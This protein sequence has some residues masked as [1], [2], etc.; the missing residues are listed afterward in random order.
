M[1]E[2][3]QLEFIWPLFVEDVYIERLRKLGP[4]EFAKG[5]MGAQLEF[6]FSVSLDISKLSTS[7]FAKVVHE[8][9]PTPLMKE[10]T[11]YF[12]TTTNPRVYVALGVP[13]AMLEPGD[14]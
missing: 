9:T 13:P 7:D 14:E 2:P 6:N 1:A 8:P 11:N 3:V 5:M 12:Q 4:S 10:I